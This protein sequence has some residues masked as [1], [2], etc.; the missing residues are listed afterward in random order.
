M[1]NLS[2]DQKNL[3]VKAFSTES[4]NRYNVSRTGIK[5]KKDFKADEKILLQNCEPFS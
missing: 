4:T 3:E 2:A 5:Y 1:K